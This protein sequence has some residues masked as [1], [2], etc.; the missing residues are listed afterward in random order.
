M[1]FIG[2]S[3]RKASKKAS[4]SRIRKE[5]VTSPSVCKWVEKYKPKRIFTKRKRIIEFIINET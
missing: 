2:L 1:Y 5:Q 3:Y 4:S